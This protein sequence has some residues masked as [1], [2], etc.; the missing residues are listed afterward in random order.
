[1]P[2]LQNVTSLHLACSSFGRVLIPPHTVKNMSTL[3]ELHLTHATPSQ[4]LAMCAA[5]Q[6]TSLQSLHAPAMQP[7]SGDADKGEGGVALDVKLA[8][9]LCHLPHLRTLTLDLEQ[10]RAPFEWSLSPLLLARQSN[11][12]TLAYLSA[13]EVDLP[14]PP[15]CYRF[16]PF[17]IGVPDSPLPNAT[18]SHVVDLTMSV[19]P[20]SLQR[21][22]ASL[23]NHQTPNLV[24]FQLNYSSQMG[25][26]W[27]YA[28][29]NH[30]VGDWTR[31]KDGIGQSWSPPPSS[32][33]FHHGGY[34]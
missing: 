28:L 17:G 13:I 16:R 10:L 32:H 9:C 30:G 3:K 31:T 23:L 25:E 7:D 24:V 12:A 22:P 20:A 27:I 14:D 29:E 1:M 4:L 34:S 8:T 26:G 21:Y 15:S 2:S 5:D 18:F 33:F 11:P 19:I 6:L